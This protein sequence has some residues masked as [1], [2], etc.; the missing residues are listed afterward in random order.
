MS[1]LHKSQEP[2]ALYYN[3]YSLCS[4]MVRFTLALSK[5]FRGQQIGV[6]E[7][8]VDIQHGGQLTEF[9]LCEVNP[10]GTVSTFK[11]STGSRSHLI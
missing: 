5:N 9:Y 10:K 11:V 2:Y 3:D 6:E 7:I 4:L 8:V 1:T